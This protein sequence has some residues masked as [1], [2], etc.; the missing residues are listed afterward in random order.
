[1]K[2]VSVII[3]V[4]NAQDTIEEC[5]DSV[6]SQTLF[7]DI[8]VIVVDDASTDKSYEIAKAYEYRYPDNT[9][10]IRCGKNGGPGSAKNIGLSYATG[11][12]VGF[13]D[14]DDAIV[15][16]MYDSLYRE[17][18]RT[19]SDFVDSGFYSQMTDSA[20]LYTSDEL[21]GV[22]DDHKKSE[23]I[24]HGGYI[25]TKL[26]RRQFLNEIGIEFRAA[27]MLE[28]LDF[29]AE[30]IA[31]ANTVSNVKETF[32]IYRD[33]PDSLS[34]SMDV[35]KY[36]LNNS[37]AIVGLYKRTVTLPNYSGIQRAVEFM[38][39][40]M[41][42]FTLNVCLNAVYLNERSEEEILP[43]LESLRSL[44][45]STTNLGYDNTYVQRGIS[46]KDIMIMKTNDQ[47]SRSLLDLQ[48]K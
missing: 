23:L 2:K 1:M 31:R 43:L 38:I 45:S 44:K 48:S 39:L 15:P 18:I 32:Y 34:K 41:Y 16:T 47:S 19:D 6:Y 25:V 36:V 26:F 14:S 11:E 7:P 24:I 10:L 21:S 29:L 22:L 20:I 9:I 13:V 33:R 27:Y 5:L 37:E 3:P 4:Y 30:I 46:K 28:D 35:I 40:R 17:A 8:E 12:Y 42:S